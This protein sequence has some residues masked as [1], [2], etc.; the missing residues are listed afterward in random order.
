VIVFLSCDKT[1]TYFKLLPIIK[2]T[3]KEKTLKTDSK[4]ES[5]EK[6]EFHK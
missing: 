3:E 4:Y 5:S 6:M 2:M 1:K